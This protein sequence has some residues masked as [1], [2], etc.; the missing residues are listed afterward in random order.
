MNPFACLNAV[1]LAEWATGQG[2]INCLH[3][4]SACSVL[5]C[6]RFFAY[7]VVTL[8]RRIAT[9]AEDLS[10]SEFIYV[11]WRGPEAVFADHFRHQNEWV[12]A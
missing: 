3:S 6:D 2:L 11:T 9:Y 5:S 1:R 12:S 7:T 4:H 8:R 10:E